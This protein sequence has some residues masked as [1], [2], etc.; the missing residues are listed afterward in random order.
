MR[1][2][3][4]RALAALLVAGTA[5]ASSATEATARTQLYAHTFCN[6]SSSTCTAFAR[7]GTGQYVSWDWYGAWEYSGDGEDTS[8]AYLDCPPGYAWGVSA[9]VTDS[10]GA[11]A[12]G[13][14]LVFCPY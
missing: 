3:L 8:S 9:I 6:A 14:V 11:T 5:A 12:S 4:L 7:G 2:T 13:D 1:P 10:S